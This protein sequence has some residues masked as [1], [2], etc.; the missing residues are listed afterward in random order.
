VRGLLRQPRKSWVWH[1]E[2]STAAAF[3]S[4]ALGVS[5][6]ALSHRCRRPYVPALHRDSRRRAILS[7]QGASD[8]LSVGNLKLVGRSWQLSAHEFVAVE[9]DPRR[10]AADRGRLP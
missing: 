3:L 1:P 8:P 7:V 10:A 6:R 2:I 4:Q 9:E 5:S